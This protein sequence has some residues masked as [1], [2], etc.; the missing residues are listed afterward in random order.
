MK[1][2]SERML[3][4]VHELYACWTSRTGALAWS[5]SLPSLSDNFKATTA[6]DILRAFD[7]KTG[8]IHS[9]MQSNE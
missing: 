8:T 4:A 2:G 6:V 5:Q 9:S 7:C 1:V 3:V